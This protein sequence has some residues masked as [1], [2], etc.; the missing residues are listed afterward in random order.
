[1]V[2]R[3]HPWWSST[4]FSVICPV[5]PYIGAS[6]IVLRF[7]VGKTETHGTVT[8]VLR[9][10]SMAS[11]FALLDKVPVVT[12]VIGNASYFAFEQGIKYNAPQESYSKGVA[13]AA[14][15]RQI[16]AGSD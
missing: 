4:R 8:D 12:L 13:I 15:L 6:L 14:A 16:Y 10:T 11:R 3:L 5:I 1:M 9:Q 7:R 2:P